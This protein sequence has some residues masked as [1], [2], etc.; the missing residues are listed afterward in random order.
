[1]QIP[2]VLLTIAAGCAA[3]AVPGGV[4][5]DGSKPPMDSPAAVMPML[6]RIIAQKSPVEPYVDF[7]KQKGQDPIPF[8]LDKLDKFRLVFLVEGRHFNADQYQFLKELI[9]NEDLIAKVGH[10]F[11]EVG[12]INMQPALDAFFNA[13]T[14]NRTTLLK[15]YQNSSWAIGWDN[16]AVVEFMEEIWRINKSR[17][18]KKRLKVHLT[19]MPWDWDKIRTREDYDKAYATLDQ[20]DFHMYKVAKETLDQS[21][22]EGSKGIFIINTRHGTINLRRQDGTFGDNTATY[23]HQRH[24]G[25]SY[26]I[27]IHDA[28]PYYD[29]Q[30]KESHTLRIQ[31]GLWDTAFRLADRAPVAVPF[32][33]SSPFAQTPFDGISTN[34]RVD[35]Q[36]YKDAYDATLYL[37]PLE[38]YSGNATIPEYFQDSAYVQEVKRRWAIERGN[39]DFQ[40]YPPQPARPQYVNED[41]TPRIEEPEDAWTKE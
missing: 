14:L 29:T 23:F 26:S 3:W 19:D 32:D 25:F 9:R 30:T 5:F 16:L 37:K 15:V 41:G 38:K 34:Y 13:D 8:V 39:N 1:M 31:H 10:I 22:D 28:N 36:T 20:R 18:I 12:S 27:K 21:P 6:P 7:I 11:V 40:P 2:A 4:S 17:P 35:G 24:P 33:Q